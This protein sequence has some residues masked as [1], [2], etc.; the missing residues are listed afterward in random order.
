MKF[1]GKM[2]DV[3]YDIIKSHKKPEFQ[4]LFK[5]YIFEPTFDF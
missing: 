3:S 1:S 2:R 5:R 4:P